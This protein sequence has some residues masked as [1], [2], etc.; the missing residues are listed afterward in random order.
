MF[1]ITKRVLRISMHF[2]PS[3]MLLFLT[4]YTHS[5]LCIFGEHIIVCMIFTLFQKYFA[6]SLDCWH[7]RLGIMQPVADSRSAL[8]LACIFTIHTFL[9]FFLRHQKWHKTL[10]NKTHLAVITGFP[11]FWEFKNPFLL[12]FWIFLVKEACLLSL[13]D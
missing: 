4:F 2:S 12:S 8:N 3:K 11:F 5:L 10:L 9:Y 13:L 1:C 7:L 6:I